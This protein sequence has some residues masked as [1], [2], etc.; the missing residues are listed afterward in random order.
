MAVVELEDNCKILLVSG[1][2]SMVKTVVGMLNEICGGGLDIEHKKNFSQAKGRLKSCSAHVV[3]L[4]GLDLKASLSQ[5]VRQIREISTR[6]L[7]VVGPNDEALAIKCIGAG[8]DDYI[9]VSEL[10]PSLIK[11][12]LDFV[13]ARS[14]RNESGF[15]YGDDDSNSRGNSSFREHIDMIEMAAHEL[16]HPATVIKGYLT[17]LREYGEAIDEE[18]RKEAVLGIEEAS[19][20]LTRLINTLLDTTRIE[21]KQF[22]IVKKPARPKSL[23]LRV[24]SEVRTHG[25]G[26]PINLLYAG[27]TEFIEVDAE[28]IKDVLAILVDNAVRYTPSGE[29][30]DIWI[31]DAPSEVIFNVADRGPGIPEEDRDKIFERFYRVEG[32][33]YDYKPGIGL[34]LFIAKNYVSAHGGWIKVEPRDGGGSVFSFG[35]PIAA[36]EIHEKEDPLGKLLRRLES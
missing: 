15:L 27:E 30:V 7:V 2:N 11:R 24:I 19:N 25:V 31:E 12:A 9:S 28:R 13:I 5:T 8:A 23:V 34:G 4:D 22:R 32:K 18:T 26:V 36:G 6:P 16:R 33:P 29:E 20:R 1:T 10:S 21:K 3:L 14:K 35:V 17:L